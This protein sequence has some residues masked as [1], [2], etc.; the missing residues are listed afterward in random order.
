MKMLVYVTAVFVLLGVGCARV[1]VEAPKE[2]IKLDVSMRLDI[3]QHVVKDID[4]IE[5]LV[6]KPP[7]KAGVK[8]KQSL[9][10]Y[11]VGT[12]YAQEPLHPEVEAAALRRRSRYQRL[13]SW[14]SQAV[15]GEN[16]SGLVEVR[17]PQE[18]SSEVADL[19][20]AENS[21]RMLIYQLVAQTNNLSLEEVEKLYAA[22]LQNDA[23]AGTPIEV[24]NEAAG[25][26][27]WKTKG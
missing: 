25:A 7:D 15:I 10:P 26:F 2:P 22:R 1:K 18:A 3:Y 24:F 4:A 8:D 5:D 23:P 9:M 11:I 14:E 20:K 21:D 19:V 12:A 16:R 17:K 13:R 6:S 27:Q